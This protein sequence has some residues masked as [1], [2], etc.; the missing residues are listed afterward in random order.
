M[1]HL[2]VVIDMQ[3]D[4]VSGAL[5][6]AAAEKII[7]GIAAEIEKARRSGV[8]VV[9][10]RDTH[11][12]D[13]LSTQEGRLLPIEHCVAGTHG[14]EIV[15]ALK[16][17]SIGA[18]V[19]DKPAF[20]SVELGEYVRDGRFDKATLVGICTDICVISN[21]FLIKAFSPETA[22]CVKKELC[23]GVT[24]ESH[25]IALNAMAAA[26]ISVE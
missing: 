20:G 5:K 23:A 14:H 18:R 1:K 26:Q 16:K 17:Y 8:E 24:A 9:F 19:F 21:A 2:L 4:F 6:N 11:K 25:G 22:V 15:A 7:P 13:Y 12:P 3:N 10:T